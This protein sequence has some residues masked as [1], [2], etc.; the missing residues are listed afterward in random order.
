MASR[1]QAAGAPSPDSLPA[2]L[3]ATREPDFRQERARRSYLALID[4]ATALFAAHGYD[5]VGTPEIAE[6][7]GVSVGTFYRYFDD[8]HEVYLE[9]ARRTLVAGYHKTI[10]DLGPER[11]LGRGRRDTIDQTI[12][13]LFDHVMAQPELTRSFRAM[14]LR[15]TQVAEL[16][17]AFEQV[18]V[19]RIATLIA[20]IVGRDVVPDPEAT[21][22]VLH[23]AATETAYGLAGHVGPPPIGA[24]RARKA[25][26]DFIERALFP[27]L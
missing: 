16:L 17:R 8:K 14:S 10:A 13:V 20:A 5:A 24:E 19:G 6:R 11:F 27:G 9:I 3:R 12:A 4:A 2:V 25:L 26:T 18:S 22:W 15:D 23:A 1:S 21:A 7:A